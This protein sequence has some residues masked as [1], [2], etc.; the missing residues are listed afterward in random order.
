MPTVVPANP[1]YHPGGSFTYQSVLLGEPDARSSSSALA[2]AQTC[3]GPLAEGLTLNNTSGVEWDGCRTHSQRLEQA[4]CWE[5]C[6]GGGGVG[7][8]L[9]RTPLTCTLPAESSRR[10]APQVEESQSLCLHTP[11]AERYRLPLMPTQLISLLSP[12]S[13]MEGGGRRGLGRGEALLPAAQP[14][15][16]D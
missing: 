12:G 10:G 2:S 5:G 4:A 9:W 3:R 16:G 6:Y 1:G 7:R 15:H 13:L 8:G 14:V 11:L